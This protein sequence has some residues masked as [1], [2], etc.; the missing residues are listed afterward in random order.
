M[1]RQIKN[2]INKNLN[3]LTLLNQKKIK[4]EFGIN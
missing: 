4:K 2:L 1:I 3:Q